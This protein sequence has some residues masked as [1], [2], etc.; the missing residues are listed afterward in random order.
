MKYFITFVST[1]FLTA[2]FLF[3]ADLSTLSFY[4]EPALFPFNGVV[5][6]AQ[7]SHDCL[8]FAT[9]SGLIK[10]NGVSFDKYEHIPFDNRTIR[11]SQIQSVF[12]DSDDILWLGTY[13][14]LERFDINTGEIKHFPVSNDVVTA[15]YRDSKRRL[16]VG[17]INGLHLC[18]DGSCK[19]FITFDNRQEGPYIGNNTVRSIS[20]DSRG[21]IYAA[22]YDGVWQY[23][24]LQ[25]TFKP[26]TLLPEGCPGKTGIVYHFI[27]DTGDYWLSVWGVG[28]VRIHPDLNTYEVFSLPD[29]RIYSLYNNFISDD[30]IAAGTWGGGIYILNKKTKEIIPYRANHNLQGALTNNVIYSLFISRYNI[31]F[32]GTADVLNIADLN[33]LSG[34]IAVPLYDEQHRNKERLSHLDGTISFL[35]SSPNYIWAA[36]NNILVRYDHVQSEPEEFPF[37]V[38]THEIN[39]IIIYTA[40]VISDTELWIG[41]NKGLFLFNAETASFTPV[42]LYND[43]I[44]DTSGF[45]IRSIYQDTDKTLWLG[46]YGAGLIHFCPRR[47]I[48]E[49][50]RHSEKPLSLSND[51]IF[52][53]RRDRSGRL[54]VGTNRGL[55]RY[56]DDSQEFISYSYD[57]D[58]PEGISSN[59]ID[60]FCEDAKGY[61]WFGTNDGGICRFDPKTEMFRTYTKA[62]GLSSNRI[63]GIT[64][65][66]DGFLLIAAQKYL[67]LFD[68][69]HET[70]QAYNI[71][72]IRQYGYFSCPP[73]TLKDK[74][75]FFFGTDRGILKISQE[76][77][78]AFRL[79]FTPIKIR[80]VAVDG[81]QINLYTEKQ[82]FSFDYKTN[83][84]KISFAI[85]YTSR[86]KKPV[87][88][89]K[90]SD[91]DENWHIAS[92][93]D[94]VR[95]INLP[96]GSYTFAVKNAADGQDTIHDSISF[97]I[98][99][100]FL[101]SPIMIWFYALLLALILFL[102]YKIH[103]LYWLQRYAELLEEKQL[104]LI[105]DNFTLKEMSMLDH[106]TG[107]GNRRYI[108][109]LGSKIWK[110]AMD[111]KFPIAVM[112]FD[113]DF[114]K[115]YNDRFGH[116]AGDELLR[117]IGADL[118]KRIRTETDLIGRYGGEE[119]LIVMYNLLPEKAVHIAEGI[120]K[121]VETMHERHIT[122][123][124]GQATISIGVFLEIPS[125]KIPFD[126]MIHKADCALYRAKQTGR[127]KVVFYDDTMDHITDCSGK[128]QKEQ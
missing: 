76:K 66:D 103:K 39:G 106:L 78:Y 35:T 79:Q 94:Y 33:R 27:E 16:W 4:T 107:I 97:T 88:A 117:L 14:G 67:N 104:T 18:I 122:E 1:L 55:C 109:I 80:E 37:I 99:P 49:Q 30:Y 57:V 105:Q 3:S 29:T 41:S 77:L 110:M 24:E 12:M 26:C 60:S 45:L 73:V 120:R 42:S 9:R 47:G 124:V 54:W 86:R 83:D 98:R 56:M 23:D 21:I 20:E 19:N 82:P 95:Y 38:E 100:S 7:D 22:T 8:Y 123:M 93:V 112:M 43:N 70:A 5:G 115:K 65:T 121:T 128:P 85:P 108:D 81:R 92:D 114:F 64:D 25:D 68:M 10:Y 126:R 44:T 69:E 101:L 51:I 102:L 116:Q 34:D 15:I 63:I 59:R 32:I 119:F 2:G 127:N 111:H 125:Q 46:T 48:L 118:K 50:Y 84:I 90:L 71:A 6:V 36:S 53:I 74:G 40:Y 31:L 75:L 28:L 89:Y 11:S 62:N 17:T 91:F 52:F 96:P 87:Y 113:I 58:R 13:S 72:N 61:L